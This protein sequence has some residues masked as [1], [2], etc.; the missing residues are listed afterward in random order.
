LRASFQADGADLE[1][2]GVEGGVVRVRLV[3]TPEAC[4]E[5][6]VAGPVLRQ[7]LE[8]SIRKAWP[9]LQ[10]VELEDPREAA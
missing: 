1:L 4:L 7:I 6:I 10:A 9:E 8:T 2:V 3:L 5:C